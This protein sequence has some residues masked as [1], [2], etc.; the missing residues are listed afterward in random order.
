MFH[1]ST[2]GEMTALE[3]RKAELAPAGRRAGGQA[4]PA[5]DGL[6]DLREE[7]CKAHTSSES[8]RRAPGSGRGL[9]ML[10]EKIILTPGQ[11][12]GEI[13]ATLYG[14]LEQIPPWTERQTLGRA[15]KTSTPGGVS[16]GVSVLVVAGAGLEPATFRL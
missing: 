14:E 6:N 7:G 2:K 16:S 12:R 11:K 10:T 4:R 3:N 1:E 15:L 9:R 13:D 8:A 5:A